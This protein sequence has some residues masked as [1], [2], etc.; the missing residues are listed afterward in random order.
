MEIVTN[1]RV[2][3]ALPYIGNG[4]YLALV[5]GFL[6]TDMLQLRIA[7]VGGYTGLVAFHVLHPNPLTIPLRWSALFILVNAGAATLLAIDKF[8][9]PLTPEEEELYKEHFSTLTRGQF[10]QLLSLG[11]KQDVPDGKLLTVEGKVCSNIYFIQKG[12]AKVYHSKKFAANIDEGGFVNDVAFQ[13]GEN[14]GAYGS[15]ITCGDCTVIAWDQN[16]LRQHLKSRQDM[17]RNMKHTLSEHLMKSLLKQREARHREQKDPQ[18]WASEVE[19][20]SYKS[21]SEN[22][23]GVYQLS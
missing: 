9:A 7:L 15:I 6:M 8:A 19:D 5:S 1:P 11:T 3:A 14:A 12:R 13:Q 10:Y 22:A 17:D 2:R 21:L 16:E 20:A 18:E 23:G 4:A